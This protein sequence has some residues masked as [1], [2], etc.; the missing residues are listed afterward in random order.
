MNIHTSD[1]PPLLGMIAALVTIMVLAAGLLALA[2][3]RTPQDYAEAEMVAQATAQALPLLAAQ[4]AEQNRHQAE[5]NRQAEATLAAAH[6][7][8]QALILVAQGAGAALLAALALAGVAVAGRVIVTQV[9]L[10]RSL[11]VTQ[12][13]GDGYILIG[14][15]KPA[16]LLDAQTGAARSTLENGLAVPERHDLSRVRLLAEAATA[17]ARTGRPEPAD[18]VGA[19]L[20]SPATK[21]ADIVVPPTDPR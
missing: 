16:G 9:R 3:T 21:S 19:A 13:I 18:W 2:A 15:D 14:R 12:V 5:Q 10:V 7:A 17:M 11:P 8:G 4:M 20:M 6:Q 1:R